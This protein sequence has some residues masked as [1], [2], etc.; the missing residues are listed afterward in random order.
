[1]LIFNKKYRTQSKL[2]FRKS[3]M[4]S[5]M[6]VKD[7][8]NIKMMNKVQV[9]ECKQYL[10]GT[11]VHLLVVSYVLKSHSVFKLLFLR[12]KGQ[13]KPIILFRKKFS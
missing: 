1:M 10:Y 9:H 3:S 7:T 6:I 11:W 12:K 13:D 5:I 2:I 4:L 8:C